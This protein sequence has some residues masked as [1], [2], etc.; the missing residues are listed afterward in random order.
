MESST[1]IGRPLAA[2][3]AMSVVSVRVCH[4]KWSQKLREGVRSTELNVAASRV[5]QGIHTLSFFPVT[6]AVT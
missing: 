1:R 5:A 4:D 6:E 3:S 2:W